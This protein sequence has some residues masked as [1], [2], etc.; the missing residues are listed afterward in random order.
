MQTK[1][2]RWLRY[3]AGGVALLVVAVCLWLGQQ[4]ARRSSGAPSFATDGAATAPAALASA[5]KAAS[6]PARASSL[7]AGPAAATSVAPAQPSALAEFSAWA[8]QFAAA[9]P[10]AQAVLLA[11]GER[12]AKARREEMFQLIQSDPEQALAQAL[13]YAVRKALPQ[14]VA[15]LIEQPVEARGDVR[16]VYLDPSVLRPGAEALKQFSVTVEKQT[17]EAYTYGP[18]LRQPSHSS[19]PVNGLAVTGDDGRSVLALSGDTGRIVDP[20]EA[21]DLIAAGKVPPAGASTAGGA[22]TVVQFGSEYQNFASAS[23]AQQFI[24][25]LNS[26]MG[27][28][29]ASGASESGPV[30]DSLSLRKGEG[31]GEGALELET[32]NSKPGTSPKAD[33]PPL[34]FYGAGSQ[35]ILKLLYL[36]VLFADDP[37][38]PQSPD[39]AQNTAASNDR[40]FTEVSYGI[41]HWLTTVTPPLRLPQKKNYYAEAE[42]GSVAGSLMS[43]ALAAAAALGYFSQ[44]YFMV[45]VLHNSI[46]EFKFGGISSGF[47]NGSPGALTHELGHNVG[48]G[49]ANFW[50]VRGVNPAPANLN[51]YSP[52]PTLDSD[53]W[54]GHDDINA[55]PAPLNDKGET[56]SMVEYGDQFDVMGSGGGH[57]NVISKNSLKWLPDQFIRDVVVNATNRVYAFDTPHITD[58]RLYALRLYKDADR[59]YWV[60]VRR[61]YPNNAWMANGVE[62]MWNSLSIGQLLID[63]TPGTPPGKQ[64]CAVIVGRTFTDPWADL[65]ITPV[66]RVGHGT[67]DEYVDVVVNRGPFPMNQPPTMTLTASSLRVAPGEPVLFGVAAS[68]PDGDT[69]A[70]NWDFG[71]LRF[72]DN[73]PFM[74]QSWD[75]AGQ[76]V[77]RCEVSDMKGGVSSAF[78]VV[79]VGSPTTFTMSG[80]VLDIFGNPLQGARVHNG[81]GPLDDSDYRYT[82]TD[83]QGYYTMGNVPP[84]TYTNRAVLFGYRIDPN[85]NDPVVLTASDALNL[86][87]TASPLPRVSITPE[88]DVPEVMTNVVVGIEIIDNGDGT[89]TTNEITAPSTG[90]F[91]IS[92]DGDLSQDLIVFF[93]EP[94]GTAVMGADYEP[95]PQTTYTFYWQTNINNRLRTNSASY[96]HYTVTI[97]AGQASTNLNLLSI[98]NAVGDGDK[99]VK[100]T[101]SLAPFDW[102]VITYITNTLVTNQLGSNINVITTNALF[103][104]VTNRVTIP[105]WELRPAAPDNMTPVWYQTYPTY[106]L[107][108][109]EA[110]LRILDDEPPDLP[111]VSVAP[112]DVLA[113]ETRGDSATLMFSRQGAP[114]TNDLVVHYT[115]S[116]SASNGVDFRPL[117]GTI[118]IPAGQAYAL[119][120]V[121]A[122]NDLFVEGLEITTVTVSDDPAYLGGG[123]NAMFGIIDDDLPVVTV[124]A[125][126]SVAAKVGGNTGTV[127]VSRAGDLT[128][129]LVV[130]YLVSGTA[131]SGLDYQALAQTLTIPAG[132][133]SATIRIVPINSASTGAKTVV[134]SLSDTPAY[135]VYSQ[136]KATVTIQ[137]NLP[138][139]T[140][141]ASGTAAEG[142]SGGSFTIERTTDVNFNS[143]LVVYYEVGGSAFAGSDYSQLG[144]NVTIPAGAVS[145]TLPVNAGG[146]NDDRYQEDYDVSG[147]ETVIVQL[148]PGPNYNVGSPSG[149]TV[150]ITDNDG[151]ELPAVGFML[152]ASSVREDAHRILIPLKCSANPATNKPIVIEYRIIAGSGLPNVNYVPIDTVTGILNFIHYR[153]PDPP[154][155][156]YDPEDNIQL[157]SLEIV[158]DGLVAGD[159]TVVFR[160]F[161]PSGYETN[162]TLIETNGQTITNLLIAKIPTN[163][164]LG[165]FNTHTVTIIDVGVNVVSVSADTTLAFE[166]G[167]V[168]A[169][170]VFT[171]DGPVNSPLTVT[172]ALTGWAASGN[173]YVSLAPDGRIGTVTFPAG[174]NSVSLTLQP[175][176]DPVEEWLEEVKLTLLPRSGYSVGSSS[177][178]IYVLSDDGTLQFTSTDYR[179]F[180]NAGSALISVVRSGDTNRAV[181]VEYLVRD[182]TATNHLDYESAG[183]NGTLVFAPGETVKSFSVPL[184]NDNSVEDDETFFVELTNPTG[185]TPLGGQR[186]ATVTILND[187]TAVLFPTNTFMANE[188]A[189]HA[190]V[191]VARV[192]LTNGPVS[193][194]LTTYDLTASNGVDYTSVATRVQFAPGETARTVLVPIRDD[195]LFEGNETVSLSLS[196]PTN[197]L[198]GPT[199]AATLVL[200]DDECTVTFASTNFL[201][202]E[203]APYAVVTVAR[204]GGAVN[205]VSVDF[206]T[207]DGSAL[208]NADY[209]AVAGTLTFRG[210][211]FVVATNGS[212]ELEFHPGETNLTILVP[213]IDDALGEGN[214][215]FGVSLGNLQTLAP[216]LPGSTVLGLAN[217]AV[218]VLDNELPG[219]VDYEYTNPFSSQPGAN[220][221]VHALALQ[222]DGQCV[223]GGEFTR[224]DGTVYTRIARLQSVGVADAFFNPG[225]G[226]NGTVYSVAI[227]P[228]NKILVGG[229]FTRM[230]TSNWVGIARLRANGDLDP[231]FNP[232]AG[233]ANGAV[234]AVAA[235]ADRK[236]LLGG[237]FTLVNG[238]P[239][240]SLAR[241]NEDGSPDGAFAVALNGAVQAIAVQ[242]DQ[243][244]LIGG[245]FT[246]VGGSARVGIARL[247]ANGNLDPSFTGSANLNGA[248]NAIGLQADGKV[249]LGGTFTLAGG[250]NSFYVVRLNADGFVDA[251]F[252]PGLGADA[253]VTSV[254]VA[255]RGQ[256]LIGGQFTHFNLAARSHF[257]RLRP[258]GSLDPVFVVGTGADDVVRAVIVQ[259]DSAAIIGGDF[260]LVNDIPRSRVARIHGDEKMSIASVEF[261]QSLFTAAENAGTARITVARS[262]DTN[263][264]FSIGYG[265]SDGTAIRSVNYLT[266]RGTLTFAPGQTS[267]T[268]DVGLLDNFTADGDRT[269]NLYLTNAP[270]NVDTSGL[271]S[272]VLLIQ[273]YL[274]AVRFSATNYGAANNGTNALITVLRDGA[275]TAPVTVTFTTSNGTALAPWD[276]LSVTTNVAF[277]PGE[278]TQTVLV[279]LGEN[280]SAVG[281]KD[282]FVHL[283][284][285]TNGLLY[286]PSNATVTIVNN[287]GTIAFSSAAFSTLQGNDAIIT[288]IRTNGAN[289]AA[290]IE[291][292]TVPLTALPGVS[293]LGTNLTVNF[294]NQ[295]TSASVSLTTYYNPALDGA[296]SFAVALSNPHGGVLIGGDGTARVDLLYP[297]TGPGGLDRSFQPGVGANS[298]VSA[299]ALQPDAGLLKFIVGGAF[300]NFNGRPHKYLARLNPD[301]AVDDSFLTPDAIYTTNVIPVYDPT[302][303]LVVLSNRLLISTNLIGIGPNAMV[304]ALAVMPNGKVAISGLFTQMNSQ[305]FVRTNRNRLAML[306][307]N[308]AV[309]PYFA[310]PPTLNAAAYALLPSS[311]RL[312]AGGSFS[313]PVSGVGRLRAD[314]SID[315]TFNPGAGVGGHV[316]CVATQ[317]SG[318]VLIGGSFLTV[319]NVLRFKLAR[320]NPSG[321]L[322]GFF[323]PLVEGG[324]VFALAVQPNGKIVIAGDFTAVNGVTLPYLARLEADGSLDLSFLSPAPN[325][326]IFAL[327]LDA[328]D[329]LVIGGDFT[330]LTGGAR[331]R[332]A[333]LM[334]TGALDSTFHPGLGANDRVSTLAV[335][336]DGRVMIGGD[337]TQVDGH[338][339]GHVA[340]LNGDSQ[341][342]AFLPVR[343]PAGGVLTLQVGA[344]PGQ[345]CILELSPDLL[346]WTPVATNGALS[347]AVTF[348]VNSGTAP[349]AGFYRVRLGP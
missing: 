216:T 258:N 176:N 182:G 2:S 102:R 221:P 162:E 71:D 27:Q 104:S 135:N 132:Q 165:D 222:P 298:F 193:V 211:E 227:T 49:H 191:T 76:Y 254:S 18:R 291:L 53:S 58:G 85:F 47:L 96:T 112:L 4:T 319:D 209:Q 29:W 280:P 44:E 13:P 137:D 10:A 214:E 220:G 224:V 60:S 167:G 238:Q 256:I 130:S 180:E 274:T 22:P 11:E 305:G 234:R 74:V 128:D 92:R 142:G 215:T 69:L 195:A 282:F 292:S 243:R 166:S 62:V 127:T 16:V 131:V 183:T 161:N 310:P 72:G 302:N 17:Y 133:N 41:T 248:V 153:Q 95:F 82:F 271:T 294:A 170:F 287:A 317:A 111:A 120:H 124:F 312:Y 81:A 218:T 63:T 138:I 281:F 114:I 145:V 323:A 237:N 123:A 269:V 149:G 172:Y 336:P 88:A 32:R 203:Y 264:T 257:A 299:V 108:V 168:P 306:N 341:K 251:T 103:V 179:F 75:T 225:F 275:V 293:F 186:L 15:S 349:G 110:T 28:I 283:S 205:P 327:A 334:S 249:V 117:P 34:P 233:A 295:Q 250:S 339:R 190:E 109:P 307:T 318:Q 35:G 40:Y 116:G 38:P 273:E 147:D 297:A 267:A 242:P 311:A 184:V 325:G 73:S 51:G 164:Y 213:L 1:T 113:V 30:A 329:R 105:G 276:Y 156:F 201:A 239:R 338:L 86:D 266:A 246:T 160:L 235:Q 90:S 154:P 23:L 300:T 59:T 67:E 270:L 348:T 296:L 204:L 65:H 177:A 115:V 340:L 260:T 61:G 208:N 45:Y 19:I 261:A 308:G 70:Y 277:A 5:V 100:V 288:L 241:L 324:S 345:I 196:A 101:L 290:S 24:G 3:S 140:L 83:S 333:R 236:V 136:N 347:G 175:I 189:A 326:P 152:K 159:K 332:I 94:T 50:D 150:R 268:F 134:I 21:R 64:D 315:A 197:T 285:P 68:D 262:G 157:I 125:T 107:A 141:R 78:V 320:L 151:S 289:G 252:Q 240:A 25:S 181:S 146:A 194:A 228:D 139:V 346:N 91:R 244:I 97:P 42:S 200:L 199:I 314:G 253:P 178:T 284:N 121:L 188:N 79:V 321:T 55:P 335:L 80:R 337:F 263:S 207:T 126:D 119:L 229:V 8:Q 226:A 330:F 7:V 48:L 89:F 106:T 98:D 343:P 46:P 212:G 148:L 230:D 278:T 14:S 316:F 129:P 223:I 173:D 331:G 206:V 344:Q 301:G 158:D 174:T 303:P 12:L 20:S 9:Q 313:L 155:K 57:F 143:S 210:H 31:R 56:P 259:S 322:D 54:V 185:G 217:V 39:G 118:T 163:A 52:Q 77:V 202:W 309:D 231:S 265:T 26:A 43:D 304:S 187:D 247:L 33:E 232:G 255:P 66:A 279:P 144:T 245:S 286:A 37:V 192:G 272:S 328:L 36:P 87:H 171:R 84:G 198:L 6:H 93:N 99:T 219:N 342:P 122:V 169:H